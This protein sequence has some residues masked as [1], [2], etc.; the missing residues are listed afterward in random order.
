[1]KKIKASR[2]SSSFLVGIFVIIGSILIISVIIWLGASSF[3][4]TNVQYLTYFDGSVEGLDPGSAVK[5]LGVPVGTVGKI[6]VASDGRLIQVTM[7]I[8]KKIEISD[9]LRVKAEMAGIAGGKFLQLYFPTDTTIAKMYPDISNIKPDFPV[10]RSSPSGIQEIEIAAREI[11]NNIMKFQFDSVSNNTVNF[12][13]TT[14]DFFKNK[15]LYSIISN[16]ETTSNDLKLLMSNANNTNFW[17]NLNN[18]SEELY[19]TSVALKNFS[20]ELNSKID[21][22]DIEKTIANASM[23]YD[24]V[25]INTNQA[26]KN[27]SYRFENALFNLNDLITGFKSTNKQMKRTLQAFTDNPS[28]ILLSNPPEPEK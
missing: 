7:L 23:R 21:D 2:S 15:K 20:D 5:Y 24:S 12:L 27:I 4:E 18:T 25:M 6:E 11:M 1:M 9:S 14:T 17:E 16:L 28:Q 3:L 19:N 26:V 22:V 10:I 13:A 8:G